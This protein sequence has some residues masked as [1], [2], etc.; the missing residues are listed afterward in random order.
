MQ[1]TYLS[2]GSNIGD[3]QYYLHE[4]IRLL[5]KHPKIMIEKV[6]DLIIENSKSKGIIIT[7]HNYENVSHVSNQLILMK[8]GKTYHLK[9]KNELI[10]KGYLREGMI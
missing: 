8:S 1:T 10:E 3:R 5:G 9:D 4:A 2:M 6:N 7:D